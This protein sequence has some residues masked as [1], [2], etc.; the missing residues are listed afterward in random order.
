MFLL[1]LQFVRPSVGRRSN[2]W[3][4]ARMKCLH[5]C[6]HGIH[7]EDWCSRSFALPGEFV[8]VLN[9]SGWRWACTE[10]GSCRYA[11]GTDH[12]ILLK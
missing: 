1:L 2:L 12:S 4:H 3:W 8:H 7:I 10:P 9:T 11:S 5:F 6:V